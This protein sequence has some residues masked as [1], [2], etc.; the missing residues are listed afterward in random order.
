MPSEHC[1]NRWYIQRQIIME[2]INWLKEQL[3]QIPENGIQID[4]TEDTR[5]AELL[6]QLAKAQEKL[7]SLGPCPRPMM[8]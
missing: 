8:G 3:R 5:I 4:K 6:L 2:E 1:V 7:S